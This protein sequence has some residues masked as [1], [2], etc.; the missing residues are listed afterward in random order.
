MHEMNTAQAEDFESDILDAQL[1]LWGEPVV[2]EPTPPGSSAELPPCLLANA[3]IET[4]Y[5]DG[6]SVMRWLLGTLIPHTMDR[7][8]RALQEAAAAGRRVRIPLG[9]GRSAMIDATGMRLDWQCTSG[10][11][12]CGFRA[13]LLDIEETRA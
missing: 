7:W 5:M 11:L 6:R 9:G 4:H 13:P 2:A 8:T 12:E 10:G 3:Q 1:A